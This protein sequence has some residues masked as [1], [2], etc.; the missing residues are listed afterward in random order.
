MQLMQIHTLAREEIAKEMK[1]ISARLSAGRAADYAEYRQQV[2]R[3]QGCSD[4]LD[5]LDRVFDSFYNEGE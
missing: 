2:G 3:L 5:A 1:S 4:A